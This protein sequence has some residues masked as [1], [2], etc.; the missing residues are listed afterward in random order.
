MLRPEGRAGGA[1][2]RRVALVGNRTYGEERDSDGVTR[3]RSSF[4]PEAAVA[5]RAIT[6]LVARWVV[7]KS[8]NWEKKEKHLPPGPGLHIVTG[9]ARGADQLCERIARMLGDGLRRGTPGAYEAGEIDI[10]E[11]GMVGRAWIL[12]PGLTIEVIQADWDRH[13]KAAGG[14][15]NQQMVDRGIDEVLAFYSVGSVCNPDARG[16]TNDM[17]RRSLAAGARVHAYEASRRAWRTL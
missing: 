4:E 1:Q 6:R 15:R 8:G 13:G 2:P 9:G 7:G 3:P 10:T 16:G 17:V 14:I 12:A 11:Y 5:A